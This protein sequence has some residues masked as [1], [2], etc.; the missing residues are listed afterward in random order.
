[1]LTIMVYHHSVLWSNE[2]FR[3]T[4]NEPTNQI[5]KAKESVNSLR[6]K[7]NGQHN[8]I[9]LRAPHM[10]LRPLPLLFFG[11]ISTQTTSLCCGCA[12]PL[13]PVLHPCLFLHSSILPNRTWC[14]W[15]FLGKLWALRNGGAQ[16]C[17]GAPVNPVTVC[18]VH[19]QQASPALTP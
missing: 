12:L 16:R 10:S 13:V 5:T 19:L 6:L 15:G 11:F 18:S 7:H 14:M 8:S 9:T 3:K 4:T 2:T 17:E 1:M